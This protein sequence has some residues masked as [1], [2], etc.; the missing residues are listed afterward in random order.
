[1][2]KPNELVLLLTLCVYV[3][4]YTIRYNDC[5]KPSE[6]KEYS[7]ETSCKNIPS[8]NQEEKK[9]QILQAITDEKLKGYSCSIVPSRRHYSNPM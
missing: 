8:L 9:I 4:S 6:I 2:T 3:K 7:T 5:T 1:M